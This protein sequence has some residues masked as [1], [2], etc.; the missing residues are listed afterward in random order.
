MLGPAGLDEA[1]TRAIASSSGWRLRHFYQ[2]VNKPERGAQ[3]QHVHCAH[4]PQHDG[5]TRTMI[6]APYLAQHHAIQPFSLHLSQ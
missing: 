1:K 5:S 3:E 4:A 6:G 2:H